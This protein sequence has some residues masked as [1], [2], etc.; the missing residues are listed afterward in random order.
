M[1]RRRLAILV[2][3][4]L[5]AAIPAIQVWLVVQQNEIIENQNEFFE[6]QVYDLVARSMTEGDHNA[7]VM[8]G[9]LL[10]NAD[11]TFLEGVVQEAFDPELAAGT[12]RA[13]SV[14]A[15]ARRLE[16]AAFRGYLVRATVR[17]VQRQ[18]GERDPD[19]LLE[20]ARALFRPIVADAADRIPQ[21]LRL[22]RR[23][24]DI[25]GELIERVDNYL[26][27]VGALLRTYGRLARSAGERERF[28]ADLEPLLARLSGR[29]ALAE[30]PFAPVYRT[31]LQDF[32]FEVAVGPEL[33]DPPVDLR[34]EGIAPEEAVR[35]GIDALR[36]EIGQD[37]VAWDQLAQQLAPQ[38]G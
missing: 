30:S 27:Q 3:S 22:G 36:E 9:A 34:D 2:F 21:V 17:A 32:L 18:A 1:V 33:G 26:L 25:D 16:D 28:H 15:P 10:A 37:A 31:V 20:E 14:D 8:T 6:I 35:R 13:A 11:L 38:G 29:S 5:A 4:L 24:D 12:Y 23:A 19:A 7:R